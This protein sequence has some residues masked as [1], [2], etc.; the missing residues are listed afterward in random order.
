MRYYSSSSMSDFIDLRA[1][2]ASHPN[3]FSYV[4]NCVHKNNT[5]ITAPTNNAFN[6]LP[7]GTVQSL[8]EEDGVPTLSNILLYHVVSGK[9][10]STDLSDGMMAETVEGSNIEISIDDA[11]VVM[12]NGA[13]VTTADVPACNGVIHVI[14]SVLIPPADETGGDEAGADN[15][16]GDD[17]ADM[18]EN[19]QV[20]GPTGGAGTGGGP[21]SN[22]SLTGCA[23]SVQSILAK[24]ES[25]INTDKR[26][27]ADCDCVEGCW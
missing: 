13:T 22:G 25:P 7:T 4:F 1:C 26:C 17:G 18:S 14:D 21:S 15:M 23:A 5:L 27:G 16:G 19:N 3:Y 10:M 8:F 24:G 6:A 2:I 9:V 20:A 11:G 12:V